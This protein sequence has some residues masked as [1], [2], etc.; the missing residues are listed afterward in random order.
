MTALTLTLGPHSRLSLGFFLILDGR[1]F[2][3]LE[4]TGDDAG[5]INNNLQIA[6]SKAGGYLVMVSKK[7]EL[8]KLLDNDFIFPTGYEDHLQN[9]FLVRV[10]LSPP[11][12]GLGFRIRKRT[13]YVRVA[14]A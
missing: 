14:D 7:D 10:A 2:F 8:P 9:T 5:K 6:V 12:G 13:T 1:V 4:L 3:R 11:G